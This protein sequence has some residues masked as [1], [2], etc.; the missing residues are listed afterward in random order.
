MFINDHLGQGGVGT[1]N[2]KIMT[3]LISK[4]ASL[5]NVTVFRNDLVDGAENIN[6]RVSTIQAILLFPLLYKLIRLFRNSEI[7][8]V[9]SSKDYI[10]VV[11]IMAW[12]FSGAKGKLLVNSH[13]APAT[14]LRHE[15][16]IVQRLSI[17]T[18]RIVYRYA[19]I[20]ANVSELASVESEEYFGLSK[21]ETLYNP[22]VSESD[23]LEECD[24][25]D[26]EF[27]S[28]GGKV[29]VSCG[30]LERQKNQE[31]MIRAFSI[32]LRTR[33]DLYLVILG[34]GSLREKL[35]D[36]VKTL[37][38]E[39]NV[40]MPGFEANPK[41]YMAHCDLFWLTSF[42]EGFGVVL[43]EALSVGAPILSVDC[44]HGPREILGGGR[45]GRLVTSLDAQENSA[46]LLDMLDAPRLAKSE[47]QRR[48]LDFE[49]SVCSSRYIS[50]LRKAAGRDVV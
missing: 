25:P 47:L 42:F 5:A 23:L 29:I 46:A 31:L 38:I 3:E 33:P 39:R 4:G 10:N 24:I 6:L 30:R 28:S 14:K 35:Q 12:R 45:F 26:H 36:L 27:F 13:V 22:V 44:P 43:V 40:S 48:A 21:V 1:V 37:G 20:V 19:D 8:Y 50:L 9:I 15:G 41:C 34:E 11:V 32:A 18:A 49:V 16:K 2:R 7:D 17:Y